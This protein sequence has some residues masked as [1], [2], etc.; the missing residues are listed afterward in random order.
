MSSAN[1]VKREFEGKLSEATAN[2]KYLYNRVMEL[3]KRNQ[4]L[5]KRLKKLKKR[6]KELKEEVVKL[7]RTTAVQHTAGDHGASTSD[8]EVV[9]E[10]NLVPRPSNLDEEL[11]AMTMYQQS[12]NASARMLQAAKEMADA[13][14]RVV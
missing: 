7:R 9:E 4:K 14:M 8:V 5:E 6:K 12:Y 13:L 3:E 11:A 1:E 2:E 10:S